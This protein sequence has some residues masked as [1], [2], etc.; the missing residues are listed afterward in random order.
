VIRVNGQVVRIDDAVVRRS[1]AELFSSLNLRSSRVSDLASGMRSLLQLAPPSAPAERPSSSASVPQLPA[2]EQSPSSAPLDS[3]GGEPGAQPEGEA[4]ASQQEVVRP[5]GS[6]PP[7]SGGGKPLSGDALFINGVLVGQATGIRGGPT[8][9]PNG[10]EGPAR[11]EAT[12]NTPLF[13]RRGDQLQG[14]TA[15]QRAYLVQ[16]VLMSM[17]L[18]TTAAGGKA[19]DGFSP[20]T[21][22][23]LSQKLRAFVNVL[24]RL[25]AEDQP[26][27]DLSLLLAPLEEG[28]AALEKELLEHH[29]L[30]Q[31]RSGNEQLSPS[32]RLAQM[33][34]RAEALLQKMQ[35][36]VDEKFAVL[37]KNPK[38]LNAAEATAQAASAATE[39]TKEAPPP[40][41]EGHTVTVAEERKSDPST[42]LELAIRSPLELQEL[43]ERMQRKDMNFPVNV[44]LP[45]PFE[46][47]AGESSKP[48]VQGAQSAE[49]KG[50]KQG[51]GGGQ[52]K[53]QAMVLV[54]EG[55]TILGDSFEEGASDEKPA[56]VINLP[57]FLI[58]V[59]PVTNA[60]FADYLMDQYEKGAITVSAEGVI[61]NL[62]NQP[63]AHILPKAKNSQIKADVSKG[64][65][66]FNALPNTASHPVLGVSWLGA[67]H[68][69]EENGLRLP[70][71][72]E[73]EKAAG[74]QI[75]QEAQP[76]KKFRYGFSN[77][78]I[79]LTWANYRE[80]FVQ[81]PVGENGTTPVG[82]YN[83]ASVFIRAQKHF[84]THDAT[85]PYGCYDMSGNVRQWTSEKV[86]KGG[87]YNSTPLELRVSARFLPQP[88]VCDHFTGFRVV[89]SV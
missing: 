64:N 52:E 58:A 3:R 66:Q 41:L 75:Q 29:L 32:Q 71:E 49:K 45:Y 37:S 38:L 69:C 43:K 22:M 24:S 80:T 27:E 87:S 81:L 18:L 1:L 7:A 89:L 8:T 33:K 56:R 85:S 14:F 16:R 84:K 55:P 9:K 28:L 73:W 53:T 63:L 20:H 76:L 46:K 11:R 57:A 26:L 86:S 67:S 60:Q 19:S 77:D 40:T 30:S 82:F 65:L 36:L 35:S 6:T 39:K 21:A 61:L 2:P 78:E 48:S 70:S 10:P 4:R 44:T 72:A 51:L 62:H 59:T 68:Y 5:A 47:K 31:T 23:Q 17:L 34:E 88:G 12:Q 83:G 25:Q 15:F 42:R 54:P 79:D 13:E 50:E 74:M